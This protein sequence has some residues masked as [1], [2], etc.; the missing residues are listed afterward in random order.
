MADAN[1]TEL[2][3]R[4]TEAAASWLAGIGAKAI[5]TEV[6]VGER[7]VADLAAF[8]TPTRTEAQR[9]HLLKYCPKDKSTWDREKCCW[10]EDE[11]SAAAVRAWEAEYAR[12]CLRQLTI[13]HEVKTSRGDFKGDDKWTR[14]AVADLMVLSYVKGIVKPE[15]LPLGWW[16]LE[17]NEEGKLLRA[18]KCPQVHDV[19]DKQRLLVV[20]QI[21]ERRHNRTQYAW[22]KDLQQ[23]HRSR[24]NE[25]TN[26]NRISSCAQMCLDILDGKSMEEALGWLGYGRERKL[27]KYV[28]E[29]L[30]SLVKR[31]LD[32]EQRHRGDQIQGAAPADAGRTEGRS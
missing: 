32:L 25:Y 21:C 2:T 3:L 28:L 11:E 24:E 26:T 12:V 16:H 1:K 15:E 29:R 8:W 19:G 6:G 14:P 18:S 30:E 7:W 5:E 9:S 22:Q 23:S 27:P 10:R 17:H 13:A 20:S 31:R 4:T